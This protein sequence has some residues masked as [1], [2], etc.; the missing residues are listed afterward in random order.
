MAL[1]FVPVDEPTRP[2]NGPLFD[3]GTVVATLG[4]HAESVGSVPH[5]NLTRGSSTSSAEATAPRGGC[6]NYT[7]IPIIYVFAVSF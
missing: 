6:R 1:E 3:P 7:D 5:R 4:F 2:A